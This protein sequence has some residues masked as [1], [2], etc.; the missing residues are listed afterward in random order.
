MILHPEKLSAILMK[1]RVSKGYSQ[2]YMAYKL[3]IS[4]K[5]YSYIESGHCKLDIIKF[6]KIADFTGTHPMSIIGK[7]TEGIPSW[8]CIETKEI[9]LTKENEK[10][11]DHIVFLKAYN[12]SL[13]DS[14]SKL[15]EELSKMNKQNF[16]NAKVP[17]MK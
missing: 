16:I 12:V 11:E 15:R 14:I 1:A 6:L 13:N 5:A 3:G 7:I 17:E 2:T 9:A 4:Q 8:E 10:L